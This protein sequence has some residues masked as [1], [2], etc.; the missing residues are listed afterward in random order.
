MT[1]GE[2]EWLGETLD[3]SKER[4][5]RARLGFTGSG[6]LE[7]GFKVGF[8]RWWFLIKEWSFSAMRDSAGDKDKV[9]VVSLEEEVVVDESLLSSTA[10]FW[11]STAGVEVENEDD[12][13]LKRS[14]KT[15][16][17]LFRRRLDFPI[18]IG[19]FFPAQHG[20]GEN[21]AKK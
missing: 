6:E 16:R 1:A 9:A 8:L 11:R 2:R 4:V 10:S 5:G 17:R 7:L 13:G 20:D 14:L 12:K 19:G 21:R 18:A 15:E 3:K